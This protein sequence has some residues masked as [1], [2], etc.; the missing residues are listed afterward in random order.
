MTQYRNPVVKDFA[1][2]TRANLEIVREMHKQDPGR[3][4]EVTQLIN[5][6]LGLLVFPQQGYMKNIPKTS[7]KELVEQGWPIP[8]VDGPYPQVPNLYQLVRMLRH[9]I[10]HFNVEFLSDDIGQLTGLRVWNENP[11]LGNAIT[12]RAVLTIKELEGITDRFIDL[13]LTEEDENG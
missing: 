1:R 7:L 8:E 2:R 12:W 3:V 10:A 9:A 11:R 5:S 6:M 4:Y 13:L